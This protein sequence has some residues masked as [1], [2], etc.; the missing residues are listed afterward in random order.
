MRST[1]FHFLLKVLLMVLFTVW[2]TSWRFTLKVSRYTHTHTFECAH[3]LTVLGLRWPYRGSLWWPPLRKGKREEPAHPSESYLSNAQSSSRSEP[4]SSTFSFNSLKT[5]W[6]LLHTCSLPLWK[7]LLQRKVGGKP[8]LRNQ[9]LG[10]VIKVSKAC[11]E[12]ECSLRGPPPPPGGSAS[13]L[14]CLGLCSRSQRRCETFHEAATGNAGNFTSLL[15]R[16][17]KMVLELSWTE[18][19]RDLC[20]VKWFL[21]SLFPL[22]STYFCLFLHT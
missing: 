17:L 4:V 20:S 16:R 6:V 3:T 18:K 21:P 2:K 7:S 15:M 13:S 11:L 5:V 1:L 22:N 8:N 14:S 12:P 10:T 9:V 19:P